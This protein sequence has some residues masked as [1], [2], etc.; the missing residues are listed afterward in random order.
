MIWPW[1][2]GEAVARG[3]NVFLFVNDFL[4]T[5]T[6]FLRF[7][8]RN[9]VADTLAGS[10]AIYAPL[11]AHEDGLGA[12]EREAEWL[13]VCCV[14]R[15]TSRYGLFTE[16]SPSFNDGINSAAAARVFYAD[17]LDRRK[18]SIEDRYTHGF[19]DLAL[20][21]VFEHATPNNNIPLLWHEDEAWKPLF[22][23]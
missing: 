20:T 19:G 18:L 9:A 3:T 11:T 21:Y 4:G 5:G 17:F 1:H 14:E 13:H 22:R 16:T 8:K 10:T 7:A 2:I 23:R 15:L 12:L 6:Q